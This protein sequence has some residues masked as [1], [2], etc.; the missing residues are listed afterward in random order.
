[1]IGCTI[2]FFLSDAAREIPAATRSGSAIVEAGPQ[3]AWR[4]CRM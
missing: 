3:E 4:R 1:M 2:R